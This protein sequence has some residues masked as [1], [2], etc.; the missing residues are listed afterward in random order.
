M[1]KTHL[2]WSNITERLLDALPSKRPLR[3]YG[4]PRGGLLACAALSEFKEITVTT[5]PEPAEVFVDDIIDSGKTR[6]SYRIAFPS[7]PFVAAVNKLENLID[8][9]LGWVIFPWENNEKISAEDF[10]IRALQYVGEDVRRE[11]LIETP[12]RVL[13]AYRELFSGYKL[14]VEN[15]FKTFSEGACDNMVLLKDIEF[16]STCEHHMLPFFGKAHVAY[17]PD[18]KVIGVSKLARLLDIFARRLQIQERI[19]EQ[20]TTALM[21]HLKPK[22]A[23]CIIEAQ[24]FCMKSRGVQKQDSIMVTS[25]LKGAFLNNVAARQ[26]LLLLTRKG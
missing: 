4:I 24:H 23:A 19:G 16:Y 6:E 25:S 26:E 21:E 15:V 14:S 11:G 1:I 20:V 3:V 10:V 7:I 5:E 9:E 22:A 17:I 18:G 8:K 13:K 12:A 2:T